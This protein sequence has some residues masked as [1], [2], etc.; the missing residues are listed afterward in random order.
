MLLPAPDGAIPTGNGSPRVR[1]QEKADPMSDT[2]A[3]PAAAGPNA[4]QLA[5]WNG[6]AGDKW[7]RLQARLDDLF[8]PITAAAVAAAAPRHGDRV[9]DV[10]CGCGDTVLAMA[11]AVGSLGSVTGVDISAP[12]LAVAGRRIAARDLRHAAV[13]KADAATEPF[14]PGSADLVFSRFGV[15]FFDAPSEA[16]INIRRALVSGGRLVFACWRPFE[17]NPWFHAPYEA[18]VP[19]LPPQEKPDPE[20]PG[21]FAFAD[22]E[23]LKR[24]LGVAGFTDVEVTPFDATLTFGRSR[25][26]EDALGFL[27]QVGP[28]AR[29]LA[30]GTEEQRAAALDAVRGVLRRADGPQGIGL[31]AQCWF[32]SASA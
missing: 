17:G 7:A 4:D 12:M 18:A 9:L 16:F 21:P 1:D 8:A 25:E 26:V 29:A 14:A 13:L 22:P 20:A 11:E 19:H 3:P 23:R 24:V 30:T 15:M 28:V 27:V 5:Y 6:E 32:V 2:I 10:G 31:G